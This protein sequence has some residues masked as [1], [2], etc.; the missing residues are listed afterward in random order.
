MKQAFIEGKGHQ[1]ESAEGNGEM[2]Y[3]AGKNDPFELGDWQLEEPEES[4]NLYP[5]WDDEIEEVR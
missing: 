1:G 2:A 4:R 3:K 5:K